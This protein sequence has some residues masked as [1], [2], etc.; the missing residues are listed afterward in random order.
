[1]LSSVP[2]VLLSATEHTIFVFD[3]PVELSMDLLASSSDMRSL[4]TEVNDDI[5][6]GSADGC[7]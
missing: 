1:M 3:F 7:A 4:L 5:E 6:S 2:S